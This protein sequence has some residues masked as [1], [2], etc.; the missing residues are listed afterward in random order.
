[1]YSLILVMVM[2]GLE[3]N[4]G[5]AVSQKE[6]TFSTAEQCKAAEKYYMSPEFSKRMNWTRYDASMKSFIVQAN[7]W[8]SND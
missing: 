7:C 2:G 5:V 3:T 8:K 6:Y 1:M 4:S